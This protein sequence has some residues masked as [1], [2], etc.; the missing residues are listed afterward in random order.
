MELLAVAREHLAEL[1]AQ[2]RDTE[3]RR[4]RTAQVIASLATLGA[5]VQKL[6]AELLSQI[7]I[8]AVAPWSPSFDAAINKAIRRR[9]EHD[10]TQFFCARRLSHV[11]A[12]WRTTALRTPQMWCVPLPLCKMPVKLDVEEW[13]DPDLTA[14]FFERSRPLPIP[15]RFCDYGNS[16][17]PALL[18]KR[19]VDATS[20]AAVLVIQSEELL[21]AM[22]GDQCPF[23]GEL[24]AVSIGSLG[25]P[26][27]LPQTPAL[28]TATKLTR[29]VL[30]HAWLPIP[31]TQLRELTLT[32]WY[33][34]SASECFAAIR[35]CVQLLMLDLHMAAWWDDVVTNGEPQA[36]PC[37]THLT[38]AVES[39]IHIHPFFDGL[40]LPA[41]VE[42]TL[43][44]TGEY[45]W[46]DN[47][48]AIAS[49]F[50]RSPKLEI[51]SIYDCELGPH[52]LQ[53]MLHHTPMLQELE[54][55]GC[56]RNA[57]V[58]TVI[59]RLTYFPADS[60]RGI[61]LA[62]LLHSLHLDDLWSENVH[63]ATLQAMVESRYTA[64]L[65]SS[66]TPATVVVPWKKLYFK[67]SK[68]GRESDD[69]D[70][71]GSAFRVRVVQLKHQGLDIVVC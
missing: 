18:R 6:P 37:L 15:L 58:D 5:P 12:A 44:I 48:A 3:R 4:A 25:E 54:L 29:V 20:R 41:L 69:D 17:L 70:P 43:Q 51:L 35:Q 60:N 16:K 30:D 63:D 59:E 34:I 31:W 39:G 57:V 7:F 62:P 71:I 47:G 55:Q 23:L 28:L 56:S 9:N 64:N 26:R 38:F 2:I 67:Y 42:F 53:T 45:E 32:M 52:E 65:D 8:E 36:L 61:P 50:G 22:V 46:S 19:I 24:R 49:F 14:I 33:G 27:T 1:D 66:H 11:C 68:E 13:A 40:A 10:Y 21:S